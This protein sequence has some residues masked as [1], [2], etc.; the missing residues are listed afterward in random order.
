MAPLRC[1]RQARQSL[2]ATLKKGAHIQIEGELRSR[3]YDS[4][5]TNSEQT[6]WEI[7]VN[8]ILKL[9]RAAKSTAEEQE[10]DEDS[11]GGSGRIGRFLINSA[12]ARLTPGFHHCE[13]SQ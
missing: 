11:A 3:K 9:D 4:K 10:D 2:P 12:E 5:K 13:A 1:L 8:S 7:R 6:V